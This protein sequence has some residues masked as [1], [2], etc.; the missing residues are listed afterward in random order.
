MHLLRI[1][2]NLSNLSTSSPMQVLGRVRQETRSD[3]GAL[4]TKRL[5]TFGYSR[6]WHE[7]EAVPIWA[8]LPSIAS[9]LKVQG[10]SQAG[11]QEFVICA[12][13]AI[14]QFNH[15]LRCSSCQRSW[16]VIAMGVK[17][18]D[19][20]SIDGVTLKIL[21]CRVRSACTA[22]LSLKANPAHV[23]SCRLQCLA[24]SMTCQLSLRVGW[25]L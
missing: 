16:F 17:Q 20:L 10:S 4:Q 24:N 22:V 11:I 14:C 15:A 5:H 7:L 23:Q 2:T 12:T 6:D 13:P 3:P 18:L 25:Y 9:K 19:W 21:S 1:M 8:R